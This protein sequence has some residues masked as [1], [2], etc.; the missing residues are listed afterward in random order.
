MIRSKLISRGYF[1]KQT[2][3]PSNPF[4][5]SHDGLITFRTGDIY[6]RAG[7]PPRLRWQGR[8]ADY[9]QLIS[10][11]TLDP[12]TIEATLDASPAIS[13]SCVSGD[14]FENGPARC[15][16]LVVEPRETLDSSAALKEIRAAVGRVNRELAPPLRIAWSRILVLGTGE[17][18]PLTRK[19]AVFRKKMKDFYQAR[20]IAPMDG[21]DDAIRGRDT[22]SVQS[23][24]LEVVSHCLS[25]DIGDLQEN[26]E[27]TF[28]EVR[29]CCLIYL[30][31][32]LTRVHS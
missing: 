21:Q 19:H 13:R 15:V 7:V 26:Q 12:S 31:N 6:T 20:L 3:A 2:D 9:I 1:N 22:E 14:T 16:C 4:S 5:I 27:C 10:G 30:I 25:I 29:P 8:K 23:A 11:E 24:V 32:K 18:L 28:A 17:T